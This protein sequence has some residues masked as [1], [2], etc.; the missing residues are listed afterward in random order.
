MAAGSV[1]KFTGSMAAGA[2][3]FWR[4]PGHASPALNADAA[5]L[6]RVF[7]YLPHSFEQRPWPEE[8]QLRVSEVAAGVVKVCPTHSTIL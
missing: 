1:N 4:A 6:L 5:E 2:S 3:R 8:E 7:D